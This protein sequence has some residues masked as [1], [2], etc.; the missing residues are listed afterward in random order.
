MACW[1]PTVSVFLPLQCVSICVDRLFPLFNAVKNAMNIDLEMAGSMFPS[2]SV[3]LGVRLLGTG[4]MPY[5]TRGTPNLF[6]VPLALFY[7][8]TSNACKSLIF[9][10]KTSRVKLVR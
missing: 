5:L 7:V 6:P 4:M 3:Y 10:V 8:P 2:L 9:E 1:C